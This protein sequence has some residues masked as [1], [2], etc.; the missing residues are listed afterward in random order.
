MNPRFSNR[1]GHSAFDR[2]IERRD[3]APD[4][5]RRAVIHFAVD[6]G[7]GPHT[8]RSIVL[9]ILGLPPE[10]QLWALDHLVIQ[11][12]Q[13]HLEGAEWFEV[14]DVAEAIWH[15]IQSVNT[16]ASQQYAEKLNRLLMRMGV[17]WKFEDGIVEARGAESFEL[18][19][20][21][22]KDALD[23]RALP[24]ARQEIHEALLDLSRR[25]QPDLTGAIQHA[26]AAL[27]CVAR[28]V[29]GTPNLTLG[30]LIKAHPHL[31]PQPMGP[32]LEKM[33]GFASERAR[34]LREG[35][36]VDWEEAEFV[37][38]VAAAAATYLAHKLPKP[39]G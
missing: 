5:F 23:P 9:E 7:V 39:A 38:S 25:P 31:F 19:V 6:A 33:W 34:H 36:S 37:V 12:A 32:A 2:P 4:E 13:R 14:Y 17:G 27:E 29:A 1:H 20:G 11:E 21:R 10:P 28:E 16:A 22:A 30:E 15:R 8:A 18:Q 3:T 24:T 26:A 35:Q